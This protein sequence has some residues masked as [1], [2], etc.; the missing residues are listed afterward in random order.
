MSEEE[1]VETLR[2]FNEK[3]VE[4]LPEPARNLFYAI[5]KIADERDEL[6][7]DLEFVLKQVLG[8]FRDNW[9]I[10][11]NFSDIREKYNIGEDDGNR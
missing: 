4:N 7:K 6:R 11:W 2:E 9:C 1:L 3:R 10:D 5:M 8:G